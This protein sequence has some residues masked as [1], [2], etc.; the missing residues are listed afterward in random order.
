MFTVIY[1]ETTK[2]LKSG[3]TVNIWETVVT[4]KPEKYSGTVIAQ[5]IPT[6][7]EAKE[8]ARMWENRPSEA[9]TVM[10][11]GSAIAGTMR[12]RNR[13][14]DSDRTYREECARNKRDG[15]RKGHPTGIHRTTVKQ[16]FRALDDI[17]WGPGREDTTPRKPR[18]VRDS[19]PEPTVQYDADSQWFQPDN[20]VARKLSESETDAL[21]E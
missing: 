10:R 18:K 8:I 2:T 14:L 13:D 6:F 7:R 15:K 19:K 16:G 17:A 5:G 1:A 4:S 3:N 9:A 20:R 12:A 21:A 11:T